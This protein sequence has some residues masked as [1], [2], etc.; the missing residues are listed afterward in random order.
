MML[1]RGRSEVI[2]VL[3]LNIVWGLFQLSG[4]DKLSTPNFIH[5]QARSLWGGTLLELAIGGNK[6]EPSAKREA[7][8][9]LVIPSL[10]LFMSTIT[11]PVLNQVHNTC[12]EKP[13]FNA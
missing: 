6:R 8:L 1:A 3:F 4:C 11:F 5:H 12:D 2:W 13:I 10:V 7:Y 9:I